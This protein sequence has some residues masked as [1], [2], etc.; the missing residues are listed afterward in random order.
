MNEKE[1]EMKLEDVGAVA[2]AAVAR[3]ERNAVCKKL[4]VYLEWDIWDLREPRNPR[5]VS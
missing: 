2:T 3:V 1:R 4:G 5:K